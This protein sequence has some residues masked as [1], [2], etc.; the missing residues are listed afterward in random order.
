MKDQS[1][2]FI[3]I[4]QYTLLFWNL[5]EKGPRIQKCFHFM[6]CTKFIQI[7]LILSKHKTTDIFSILYYNNHLIFFTFTTIFQTNVLLICHEGFYTITTFGKI[8]CCFV[9]F[10]FLINKIYCLL[11]CFKYISKILC[12]FICTKIYLCAE[13]LLFLPNFDWTFYHHKRDL[14]HLMYLFRTEYH[15]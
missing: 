7:I 9:Y 5:F 12:Y 14:I 13:S 15:T 3:I 1:A 6:H 2:Y 4:L 11:Y 10:L 8:T